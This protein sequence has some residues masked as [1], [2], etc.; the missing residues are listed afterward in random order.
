MK[1]ALVGCWLV[2]FAVWPLVHYVLA[3][4]Y[5]FS[6]SNFAGWATFAAPELLPNVVLFRVE[7]QGA[8]T[9]DDIQAAKVSPERWSA[10]LRAAHRQ[11]AI[12]RAEIGQLA[13]PP[14]RLGGTLLAEHG[15]TGMVLVAV[16]TRQINRATGLME[17]RIE[18]YVYS[19][20]AKVRAELRGGGR[21]P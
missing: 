2:A 16:Q 8:E 11:Y 9:L 5:G 18:K 4:T 19:D 15:S 14:E 7:L 6:P 1:R 3:A 10:D 12:E 20:R 21:E 13:P 17:A